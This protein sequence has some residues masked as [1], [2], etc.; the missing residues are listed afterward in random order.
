MNI[1]YIA[2]E[3][4]N[5]VINLCNKICE[6]GHKVVCVVQQL[7]EYDKANPATPHQNLTRVNVAYDIMFNP[8]L[9]E[10]ELKKFNL[11]NASSQYD[12]IY[13]SHT[14]VSPAI[15]YLGRRY[16]V[17][18]GVMLLD[19]PT[20]LINEERFRA[21]Q[22]FQWF[23]ILKYANS[24]TFN[25]FVARD[26]YKKFT[27]QWFPDEN[28]ITYAVNVPK[29]YVKSG[30]KIKG[31]YVV[32]AFRLNK[33][34]N[35]SMITKALALLDRPVKQVV[36]GRDRGDLQKIKDIAKENNIELLTFIDTVTEEQKYQLI[37][38]SSCLVYPQLSAYIGGLSPW[39]GMVIGKPT[40]VSD[41]KVLRDLFKEHVIYFNP[42]SVE[43][44]AEKIAFA[45]NLNLDKAKDK[46]VAASDY[47]LEEASFD[48]MADKLIKVFDRMKMG[49]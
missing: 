29:Q 37:R 11:L 48:L 15:N 30:L 2:G 38:D 43:D 3:S 36:I 5:W 45:C 34:K 22:W 21:T 19:I 12:I 7:D 16:N 4:A 27:N 46:L 28:V 42:E 18:W 40:I 35:A 32:S 13:G 39:E 47:A 10:A 41:Y 1:L 44:L 20:N 8:G 14:L 31:D 25:T 33:N 6:K 24:I 26:E 17:P 9:L 49:L 23:D